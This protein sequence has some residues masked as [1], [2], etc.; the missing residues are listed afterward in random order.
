MGRE[1]KICA[2]ETPVTGKHVYNG[3]VKALEKICIGKTEREERGLTFH[4]W[5][6]FANTQY[7]TGGL[8]TKQV[9]AMTGHTTKRSTDRY[10]HFNPLEFGDAVKVQAALLKGKPKKKEG[11]KKERPA[12]TIYKP[13]KTEAANQDKAS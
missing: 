2:G 10:T 12:L 6:H 7:L 5:R 4:A 9:Q 13:E 3:F 11:T 8:T 1:K